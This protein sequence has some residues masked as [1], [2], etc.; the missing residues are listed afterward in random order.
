MVAVF[1]WRLK[2]MEWSF[3]LISKLTVRVPLLSL[4]SSMHLDFEILMA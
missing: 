4:L 2:S 1:G 3:W